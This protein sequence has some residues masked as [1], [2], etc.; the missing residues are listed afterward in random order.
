MD[1]GVVPGERRGTGKRLLG[2]ASNSVPITTAAYSTMGE[3][4]REDNPAPVV[5]PCNVWPWL[6]V[7][8]L[9]AAALTGAV[10]VVVRIGM[11]LLSR[12]LIQLPL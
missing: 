7:A 8:V 2:Q 3:Q 5:A 11:Q 6:C 12:P 4:R 9:G 10:A 1:A